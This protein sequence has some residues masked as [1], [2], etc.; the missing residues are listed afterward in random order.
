MQ[1][2]DFAANAIVLIAINPGGFA[3]AAFL[4]RQRP[5]SGTL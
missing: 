3:G 2:D 5:P 1:G 4:E